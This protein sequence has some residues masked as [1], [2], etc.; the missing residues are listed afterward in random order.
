MFFV[1]YVKDFVGLLS[2]GCGST[3]HIMG[4]NLIVCLN[5]YVFIATVNCLLRY[6]LKYNVLD[7][8]I[9]YLSLKYTC[10]F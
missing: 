5:D 1:L 4:Y 7:D 10:D 6:A 2:I 9:N 3:G 8:S